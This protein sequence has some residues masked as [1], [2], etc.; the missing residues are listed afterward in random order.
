MVG[1][2]AWLCGA[3]EYGVQFDLDSV[4]KSTRLMSCGARHGLGRRA[5][6]HVLVNR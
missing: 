1:A 2:R 4:A 3:T 6:A 5:H